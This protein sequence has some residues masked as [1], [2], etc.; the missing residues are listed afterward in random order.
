MFS[1]KFVDAI[2]VLIQDAVDRSI[3]GDEAIVTAINTNPNTI[4]VSYREG[5]YTVGYLASYTPT[6][7]DVVKIMGPSNGWYVIGKLA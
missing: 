5:T 2:Q 7:G 3:S 4:D 6:V 1:T